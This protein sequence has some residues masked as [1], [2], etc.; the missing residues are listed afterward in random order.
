MDCS[1]E[2]TIDIVALGELLI[3]MTPNGRGPNGK[4]CFEAN[5]G[6]APGNVLSMAANLGSKC[7]YISKVGN[8][9]FGNLLVDEIAKRNI[10][11]S[12]I[13]KDE[14]VFTT[15]A[16]VYL[17]DSGERHFNFARKPGADSMIEPDDVNEAIIQKSR[18]LCF[19]TMTLTNEPARSAT[20]KGIDIARNAGCKIA[21]DPNIRQAIWENEKTLLE[22]V[23]YGLSVCQILKIS[24]DELFTVFKQNDLDK[25]IQELTEKYP[26]IEIL[27]VTCG[28]N[29]NYV[30]Q[31]KEMRYI[32]AVKSESVLDTTGAG[33][34]FF[35]CCL[36]KLAEKELSKIN[37][38][39]LEKVAQFAST[40]ASIIIERKGA[41]C[42]MP[43]HSEI[44]ERINQQRMFRLK[45]LS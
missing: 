16:F 5:P 25:A 6:G 19:G 20:K 17:D 22:Q 12:S 21:F 30:M 45:A 10:D 13:S 15:L 9:L 36:N 11:S 24:E 29:G 34:C 39:Y 33:D 3:D 42:Q 35:G 40:A 44:N 26:N 27:F 14:K 8:D 37:I 32:P 4:P 31:N 7:A 2:K 23:H 38:E 43:T 41:L 1:N 18:I 28:K